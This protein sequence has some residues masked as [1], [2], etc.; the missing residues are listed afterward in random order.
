M[1]DADSVPPMS[2]DE[3]LFDGDPI[4]LNRR[5]SIPKFPTSALPDTIAGMVREVAE[6]TQTD[7]AMAGTSALSALSAC[8][9]GHAE[10]EVR[11]GWREPCNIFTVTVAAP[12][13]RKSAVQAAMVRPLLDVEQNL[14]AKA[15]ASR[16]EAE[17]RKQ[18]ADEAT[19]RARRA[20]ASSDKQDEALADAIGFA[21]LADEIE[22]PPIPRIVADDVTP[23]AAGT[24]MAEQGGRLAI[25]S[26]EG[27]IFDIVAGRYQGGIAN[28]D[29]WLKGHSGDPVKVDRKGRPPEYIRRPAMTIGLMVQPDVLTT[30]ASNRQFRGRGLL[31]RILYAYPASKVGRRKIGADPA[32]EDAVRAYGQAVTSLAEGMAGWQGDP[33]VLVLSDAAHKAITAIEKAVE[34]TLAGDGE[35]AA[36]ADWGAKYVGAIARLAG[37]IHLAQRGADAGPRKPIDAETVRAAHRIGRYFK[38]CAIAAFA[39]MG[40]DRVTADAVYLL[41]VI[42]RLGA[43]EVSERDLHVAG[44]RSRFRSKADLLPS[45]ERLVEHGYLAPMPAAKPTGGRPPSPRYKVH[46]VVMGG[47]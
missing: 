31:A 6:A 1:I 46:P 5:P 12:G 29:L 10:V 17:T 15:K 23:E 32:D 7:E 37:I 39:E 25:I 4:P 38:C 35:L 16:R 47:M 36:L 43:D 14:V 24:L 13:E 22:V 34:P 28:L 45:V 8:T 40:A 41:D 2:D 20:A 30:V 9:G 27:G 44:S 21:M 3:R 42:T 26:A 18:V 11:R 33:A 19:I